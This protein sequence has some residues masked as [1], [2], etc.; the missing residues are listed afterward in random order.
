MNIASVNRL[1]N[2]EQRLF[3]ALDVWRSRVYACGP[4]DCCAFAGD[5]IEAVTGLTPYADYAGYTTPEQARDALALNGYKSLRAALRG[6][7]GAPIPRGLALRGD[8]AWLPASGS[9]GSVGVVVGGG[10][11]FLFDT[12]WVR[13]PMALANRYYRVGAR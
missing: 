11:L 6:L 13:A 3:A 2:W 9:V 4:D 12:G 10:V 7:C 8:I 1:P 5:C